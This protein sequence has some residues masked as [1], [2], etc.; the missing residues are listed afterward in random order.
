MTTPSPCRDPFLGDVFHVIFSTAILSGHDNV[1]K[2]AMFTHTRCALDDRSMMEMTETE[3]VDGLSI[4][5]VLD[6]LCYHE[7]SSC[8]R[9]IKKAQSAVL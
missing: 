4:S 7:R 2:I 8:F 6:N 1:R 5:V 3:T 9:A